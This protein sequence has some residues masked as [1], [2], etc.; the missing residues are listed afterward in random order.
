MTPTD[1]S[2]TPRQPM[3]YPPPPYGYTPKPPG[4]HPALW[5]G[6]GC[7]VIALVL[8]LVG[9]TDAVISARTPL[10]LGL[11]AALGA[12]AAGIVSLTQSPRAQVGAAVLVGVAGLVVLWAGYDFYQAQHQLDQVRQCLESLATCGS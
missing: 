4:I 10:A 7:G 12:V 6:L 11:V 3:Q 2:Y 5:I 9:D 1:G 8:T